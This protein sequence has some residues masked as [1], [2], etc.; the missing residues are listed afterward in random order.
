MLTTDVKVREGGSTVYSNGN[1]SSPSLKAKQV[2]EREEQSERQKIV[3]GVMRDKCIPLSSQ[4]FRD[5]IYDTQGLNSSEQI[6]KTLDRIESIYN[7]IFPPTTGL[8]TSSVRHPSLLTDDGAIIQAFTKVDQLFNAYKSSCIDEAIPVLPKYLINKLKLMPED[9]ESVKKMFD[10][11]VPFIREK[12]YLD[13]EFTTF[14]SLSTRSYIH[15]FLGIPP[16]IKNSDTSWMLRELKNHQLI[17]KN[18]TS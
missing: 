17:D 18:E 7:Q 5:Y 12:R 10:P 2:A 11:V 8:N 3:E 6:Q 16:N 13:L 15:Y 9:I 1:G 14:F 4:C